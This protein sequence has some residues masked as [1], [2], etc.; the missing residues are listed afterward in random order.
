MTAARATRRKR[1]LLARPALLALAAAAACA[2]ALAPAETWR[3][4]PTVEAQVTASSNPAFL[5]AGQAEADL[6]VDVFP[7]LA[8]TGRGAGLRVDGSIGANAVYYLNGSLTNRI[9]PRGRLSGEAVVVE[10]LLY[11]DASVEATRSVSDPFLGRPEGASTYNLLSAVRAEVSPALVYAPSPYTRFEARSRFIDV[12][13]AGEIADDDPRRHVKTQ[14][15]LVRFDRRPTPVGITLEAQRETT[16]YDSQQV[17]ALQLATGRATLTMAPSQELV[18]GLRGGR[19]HV[20]FALNEFDESLRGV[21]LSWNPSDRTR[22]DVV[23]E[24]RFFGRGGT[25]SFTHR[26]PYFSV[27]ARARREPT[28]TADSLGVL[29]A[30]S[31]LSSALDQIL[32]TRITNPLERSRVVQDLID[33]RGLSPILTQALEIFSEAA[34]LEESATLSL[35]VLGARHFASLTVFRSQSTELTRE[36][37]SSLAISL[38]DARQDGGSLQLGRR[39]ST[40]SSINLLV[41]GTRVVGLGAQ[42]GLSSV[43]KTARISFDQQ[44]GGK[45]ITSVGLQRTLVTSTSQPFAHET[46]A[47]GAITHRF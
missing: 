27:L 30:G 26:S 24:D 22:L 38:N 14:Q 46:S 21:T 28:T 47:F 44:L 20:K 45:T 18:L 17:S 15:D 6:I 16:E 1:S 3:L 11:L 12:K 19:E 40:Q 42:A 39:L 32:S 41:S 36:G 29:P 23:A 35:A 37:E 9:V 10:R 43:S 4:E 33:S 5:P 31:D 13:T 34:Q 8:I 25:L 7:Q 2:P